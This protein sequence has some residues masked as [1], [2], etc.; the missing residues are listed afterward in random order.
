MSQI[1]Q[2]IMNITMSWEVCSDFDWSF[3]PHLQDNE[4]W[5]VIDMGVCLDSANDV[6]GVQWVA[7]DDTTDF[8]VDFY[9]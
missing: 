4:G 1:L 6:V 9:E 3:F 7:L 5:A 8:Q 2:I